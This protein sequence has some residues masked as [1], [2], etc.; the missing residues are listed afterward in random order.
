M[1]RR[2][3]DLMRSQGLGCLKMRLDCLLHS[4]RDVLAYR[5]NDLGRNLRITG[6]FYPPWTICSKVY[7]AQEGT[8]PSA[9][10]RDGAGVDVRSAEAFDLFDYVGFVD[11]V[12]CPE[13]S[14]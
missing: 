2:R 1:R 6:R 4:L 5:L 8:R 11:T 3:S 9:L 12:K 14:E 10:H 13:S 7:I